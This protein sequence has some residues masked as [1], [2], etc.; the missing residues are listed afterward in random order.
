MTK[1]GTMEAPVQERWIADTTREIHRFMTILDTT[2]GQG[3]GIPVAYLP[4]GDV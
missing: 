3:Q 4:K 2:S 1:F